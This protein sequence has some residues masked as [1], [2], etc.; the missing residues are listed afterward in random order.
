[1]R[2]PILKGLHVFAL[3]LWFGGT[4]FFNFITAPLIFESFK[5]VVEDGPSSRTAY[6]RII[7]ETATDQHKKELA[8]ALAGAAVGPVFTPYF[9]MQLCCGVVALL[10][11]LSWFN[12]EGRRIVHRWRVYLVMA[13]VIAVITAWPISNHV[14][15]LRVQRFDPDQS[16][17][18]VARSQ[19]AVWHLVS[20]MLSFVIAVLSGIAL[21]L[22]GALPRDGVAA[23]RDSELADRI[24][25]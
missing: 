22:A 4:A 24:A 5:Q 10:T 25:T 2:Q 6:Q 18:E 3:G 1:M 11:A 21:L 20:L 8:S 7:P 12:A 17:A 23:P 13:A 9:A 15:E 19:F 16:R 14:S